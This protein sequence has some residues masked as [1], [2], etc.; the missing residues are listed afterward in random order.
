MLLSFN[1]STMY[2][3]WK[4]Q[5]INCSFDLSIENK[6]KPKKNFFSGK[7]PLYSNCL[8]A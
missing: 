8:N 6:A 4:H 2:N 7:S 3:V 1:S 5:I